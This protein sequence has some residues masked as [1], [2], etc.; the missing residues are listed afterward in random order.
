MLATPTFF[1]TPSQARSAAK[2]ALMDSRVVC[3]VNDVLVRVDPDEGRWF[4]IIILDTDSLPTLLSAR[5]Q[6]PGF[7]VIGEALPKTREEKV[8]STGER[9]R[10]LAA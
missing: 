9:P 5:R 10:R 4:G 2:K 8:G 1:E 6:L 7:R 3:A